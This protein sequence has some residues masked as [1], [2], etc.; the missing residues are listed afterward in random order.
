MSGRARRAGQT[1]LKASDFKPSI[2]D[3]IFSSPAI[4]GTTVCVGS[5]DGNLYAVDSN[6]GPEL[7]R[8]ATR[9]E[10]KSS[11]TIAGETVVIGSFDRGVYGLNVNAGLERWQFRTRNDVFSSPIIA[12]GVVYIGSDDGH[13]YALK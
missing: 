12:D 5:H 3:S 11:P 13:V 1:A 2:A 10:I 8:F 4:L 6:T 9:G 7:S